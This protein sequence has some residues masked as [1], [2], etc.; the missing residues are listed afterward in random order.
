MATYPND[1]TAPVTG[2]GVASEITYSSTGTETVFNLNGTV[3]F[4]G[5]VLAIVDGVV[6][7]TTNYSTSNGG[8]TVTFTTAPNAANLTLKTLSIPARFQI[9]RQETVTTV[10]EYS[11]TTPTLSLI[12][13]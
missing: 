1:A 7:S 2:F 12:H 6:Q 5:E 13:I 11:N 10:A 9:T 8:A 4:R 3:G